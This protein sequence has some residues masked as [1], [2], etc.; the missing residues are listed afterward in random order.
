MTLAPDSSQRYVLSD[1]APLLANLAALWASEPKL[2][3]AIESALESEPHAIEKSKSGLP[4]V[5]VR[6]T[7]G[8]AVY[9]HSRYEPRKEAERLIE[10]IAVEQKT[11][12]YILGLGL[13]YHLELL[14]ERASDEAIFCIFEP[15]IQMIRAAMESRDLSKLLTSHRLMWFCDQDKSILFR[16]GLKRSNMPPAC[17]CTRRF[18]RR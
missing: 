6:T 7:D 10:S 8:R 5:S 13:G 9:L 17:G 18:S 11:T 12:F 14:F 1:E 16:S 2:A 3:E 15:D 4:T